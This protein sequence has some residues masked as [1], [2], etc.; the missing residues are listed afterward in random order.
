MQSGFTYEVAE[1]KVTDF[2]TFALRCARGF[3]ALLHQREDSPHDVPKMREVGEYAHKALERD[4]VQL[5]RLQEMTVDEARAAMLAAHEVALARRRERQARDMEVR[6]RYEAML[7]KVRAW[8][9]PTPEHVELQ[10]FMVEQ[11]VESMRF[12]LFDLPDPPPPDEDAGR[13]LEG[14]RE[15]ARESVVRSEK[16]LAEE[17]ER[18][19]QANAWITALYE[20]LVPP[21]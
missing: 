11:I 10:G 5:V 7:A 9:P 21:A 4:R 12:D 18:C 2:P 8:E 19:R 13:W 14:E 6:A 16:N 15:R 17:V 20:S 1:G 3:G